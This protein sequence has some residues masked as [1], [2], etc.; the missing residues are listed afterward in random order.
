MLG[1]GLLYNLDTREPAD[2]ESL[3]V[4]QL[5]DMVE[6]PKGGVR[7]RDL[8]GLAAEQVTRGNE[9]G[10]FVVDP[11]D[12]YGSAWAVEEDPSKRLSLPERVGL[13]VPVL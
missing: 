7:V 6:H 2:Q 3:T 13:I 9:V 1:N 8:D 10:G 5:G 4:L 12:L 11:P